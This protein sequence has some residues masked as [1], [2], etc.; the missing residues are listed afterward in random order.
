VPGITAGSRSPSFGG[1]RTTGGCC[2]GCSGTSGSSDGASGTWQL[3]DVSSSSSN[4]T[5]CCCCTLRLVEFFI[6]CGPYGRPLQVPQP[7]A[8]RPPPAPGS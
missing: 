8:C 2:S 5:A 1:V 6:R 4:H 7:P 3:H